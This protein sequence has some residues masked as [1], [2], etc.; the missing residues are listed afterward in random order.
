[1][2]WERVSNRRKIFPATQMIRKKLLILVIVND[3]GRML[4]VLGDKQAS[5][6]YQLTMEKYSQFT[7]TW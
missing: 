7:W 2:M 4:V 5:C 1:M 3:L 6:D